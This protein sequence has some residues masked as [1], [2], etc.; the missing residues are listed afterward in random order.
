[1]ALDKLKLL[2]GII[3]N[4]RKYHKDRETLSTLGIDIIDSE[5]GTPYPNL[6]DIINIIYPKTYGTD[7]AID[8]EN[9]YD[10]FSWWLWDCPKMIDKDSEWKES[11]I[12]DKNGI[13]IILDTIEKLVQYLEENYR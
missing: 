11:Y 10:I 7:H 12:R 1:V 13:P 9:A 8:L 4:L 6:K 5:F 3:D 2:T